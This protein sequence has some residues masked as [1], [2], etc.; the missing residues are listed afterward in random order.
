M[1][2]LVSIIVPVYRVEDY[3]HPCV[4]SMIQQTY[5][6]IEII[7]VDDGSPDNCGKIC[8]QYAQQDKRIRVVHKK[9][10]GL[11]DA[12]N[13]GLDIAKGEYIT[14][15]DSDDWVRED[16]IEI[17]Y[18]LL[19]STDSDIA[20]CSYRK[21][22]PS[23][24][25]TDNFYDTDYSNN[26]K[27]IFDT[28]NSCNMDNSQENIF[29]YSNL[30]ALNALSGRLYEQFVV[31]CGKLYKKFLFREIQFPVGKV[32]EDEFTTYKLIYKARKIVHTSVVMYFYRQRD[33]SI[34]ADRHNIQN[35]LNA[36]EGFWE[37]ACF[38]RDIG[39]VRACNQ[40]SR[41]LFFQYL[42]TTELM[43]NTI[44]YSLRIQFIHGINKLRRFMIKETNQPVLFWIFFRMAAVFPSCCCSIYNQY[45]KTL[46]KRYEFGIFNQY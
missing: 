9:N 5:K 28:D 6:Q 3:L 29:E 12:R 23:E 44:D 15:I 31:A 26:K 11:S 18:G 2:E 13:A 39:L 14:F 21:I 20:V 24:R 43:N 22:L 37:R 27:T 16:Y 8:D 40:T 32:H 35:R 17:L 10:G 34:T 4:D 38:L 46:V 30:E 41:A 42:T 1:S 33:G 45:R 19:K 36:L 7:L 25:G